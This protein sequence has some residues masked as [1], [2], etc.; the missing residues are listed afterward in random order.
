MTFFILLKINL[1]DIINWIGLGILQRKKN[2][3]CPF[4]VINMSS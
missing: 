4:S 1:S 2:Y 3:I